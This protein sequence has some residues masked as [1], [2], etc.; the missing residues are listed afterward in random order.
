MKL[1]VER[2]V[3]SRMIQIGLFIGC[4]EIVLLLWDDCAKFYYLNLECLATASIVRD[5]VQY[6]TRDAHKQVDC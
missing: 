6:P 5:R 2:H 1:G 4:V 3:D